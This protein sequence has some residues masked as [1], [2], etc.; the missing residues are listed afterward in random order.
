MPE[1][2][3]SPAAPA[4]PSPSPDPS[5]APAPEPAPDPA[6]SPAPP[7]PP[8]MSLVELAQNCEDAHAAYLSSKARAEKSDAQAKADR[9]A[10]DQAHQ[11]LRASIAA[12][13]NAA[14]AED[15]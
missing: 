12:C 2:N 15:P 13:V 3:D 6:P 1:N 5:P 8:E 9:D 10:A 4:D 7:P 14:N 11:A